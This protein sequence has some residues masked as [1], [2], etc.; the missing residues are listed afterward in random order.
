VALQI[1]RGASR[2]SQL[3]WS[4]WRTTPVPLLGHRDDA[5]RI[6]QRRTKL[7]PHRRTIDLDAIPNTPFEGWRVR[8]LLELVDEDARLSA[9]E[10]ASCWTAWISRG[11]YGPIEDEGEPELP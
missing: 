2:H 3:P 6:A 10:Q 9:E 5:L 7:S 1:G 4:A 8:V 11:P